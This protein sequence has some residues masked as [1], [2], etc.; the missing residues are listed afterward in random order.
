LFSSD[1]AYEGGYTAVQL[2]RW[3]DERGFERA[4]TGLAFAY[5]TGKQ[6]ERDYGL[7]LKYAKS[8]ME[9]RDVPGKAL[10]GALLVAGNKGEADT[11]NG[12]RMLEEAAPQF[13]EAYLM[14]G[15]LHEKGTGVPQNRG[16]ALEAYRKAAAAGLTD[17]AAKVQELSR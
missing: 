9:S 16:L 3:A 7:A 13:A 6:V 15:M 5:M 14:L 12:L 10:Y 8:A 11:R 2:L 17:A 1:K 4:T